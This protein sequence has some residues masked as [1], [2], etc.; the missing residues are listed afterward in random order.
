VTGRYFKKDPVGLLAGL[1]VH[2]YGYS[3]PL[4]FVDP[5]GLSSDF[6]YDICARVPSV[7]DDDGPKL[8]GEGLKPPGD[9]TQSYYDYLVKTKT[10]LCGKRRGCRDNDEC[11]V[12]L[13]KY[14]NGVRCL[15]IRRK[16]MNHCFRGGDKRHQ[17]EAVNVI[18]NIAVCKGMLGKCVCPY[19]LEDQT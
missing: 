1:N 7:C 9:C 15:N 5:Y 10:E 8:P 16:I 19:T 2:V 12:L 3:S 14:N 11:P 18:V 4:R 13:E 6:G 17:I